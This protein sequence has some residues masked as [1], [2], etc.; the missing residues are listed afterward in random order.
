MAACTGLWLP[1]TS[2]LM[3]NSMFPFDDESN[4]AMI[5][6][7]G[8]C[9][10]IYFR[11]D[12]HEDLRI[13]L[14]VC[15]S[16]QVSGCVARTH[17]LLTTFKT[18]SPD[19]VR[20]GYVIWFWHYGMISIDLFDSKEAWILIFCAKFCNMLCSTSLTWSYWDKS[21]LNPRKTSQTYAWGLRDYGRIIILGNFA[22]SKSKFFQR[23][24]YSRF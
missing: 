2:N 12:Q 18:G 20:M 15:G 17:A 21:S 9:S 6:I 4:S 14:K 19:W 1:M 16:A 11:H 24:S 10:P 5:I 13:K 8:D 23:N 3:V 22:V 7:Q